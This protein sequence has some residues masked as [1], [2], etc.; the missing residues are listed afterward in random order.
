MTTG[1]IKKCVQ[2]LESSWFVWDFELEQ[3]YFGKDADSMAQKFLV[4]ANVYK[5]TVKLQANQHFLKCDC[6][7][8]ERYG[9]PCTH[10]MK[11]T[12]EINETMITVQHQKVYSVH[13]GLPNS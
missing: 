13:F 7:N 5:V 2:V 12:D 1:R 9:I 3:P 10:I 4:F 11:I 8:F 6:L